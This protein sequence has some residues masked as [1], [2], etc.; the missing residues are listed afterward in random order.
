MMAIETVAAGG[1]S[2]CRVRRR[3]AAVGPNSAGAD[4][5]PACYGRGG[6][7]AVTDVNFYLGRILP[8]RFPFPL[9][10]GGRRGRLATLSRRDRAGHRQALLRPSSCATDLLRVANANMVKAIQSI[11]IAKGCDPRDYVLVAFGGAAGQHA[12]AVADDLGIGQILLH[13]D[14]GI[15]S[16]YGIGVADVVRHRGPRH[17]SALFGEAAARAGDVVRRAA[18]RG[19]GAKSSTKASRPIASK[20]AARSTCA[21]GA[22]RLADHPRARRRRLTPTAYGAAHRQTVRLSPRR[23]SDWKSSRR[24]SKWSAARSIPNTPPGATVAAQI[25]VPTAS[26]PSISTRRHV[27]TDVFDRERLQPGDRVTGPGHCLRRA[28]DNAGRPRLAG[29]RLH[30]RELVLRVR[31]ET[32]VAAASVAS[33]HAATRASRPPSAIRPCSKSSTITSPASPSRWASRCATRPAA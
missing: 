2:I 26:R 1:G 24:A 25:A 6:P 31:T 17:L 5:G 16:A 22:R 15:L 11:S 8:E 20:C 19:A 27:P 4:P 23:P 10:R 33:G 29:R 30:A 3:E 12:C 28:V 13:P 18:R 14:A 21:I 32:E 9:D 7:L